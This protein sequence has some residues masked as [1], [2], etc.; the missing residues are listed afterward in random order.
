MC[1][2]NSVHYVSIGSSIGQSSQP[3]DNPIVIIITGTYPSAENT[4]YLSHFPMPQQ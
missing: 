2:L 1:A 3:D 4:P